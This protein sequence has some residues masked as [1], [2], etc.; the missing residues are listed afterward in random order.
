LGAHLLS[1]VRSRRYAADRPSLRVDLSLL[2][3]RNFVAGLVAIAAY[4]ITLFGAIALLPLLTEN[5]LAY[6]AMTAGMLFVPR[7]IVSA[8]SLAVTGSLLLR[9]FDPRALVAAGLALS[10]L[11]TMVMTLSTA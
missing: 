10:A 8:I 6:P 9:L 2:K 11:G 4:G 5:L 7:A 1:R 3:D